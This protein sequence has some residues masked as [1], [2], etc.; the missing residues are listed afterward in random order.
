MA[1][2]RENVLLPVL[3]TESVQVGALGGEVIVRGM[4]LR[5]RLAFSRRASQPDADPLSLTYDL[6]AASVLAD[7]QKPVFTAP[8][9]E[10]FSTAHPEAFFELL[11]VAQRLNGFAQDEQKKT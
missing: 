1:I 6:V 3:P 8:E 4:L 2:L 5:E 11:A 7:D 10:V 9:W